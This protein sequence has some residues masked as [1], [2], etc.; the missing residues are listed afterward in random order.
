MFKAILSAIP[1]LGPLL[2]GGTAIVEA[3]AGNRAARDAAGHETDMATHAQFA[4][5]FRQIKGRTWW[6]SL[7]DGLNRLPR[8]VIVGM[9]I[10]Y[11]M[12]A[13]ADPIE[14]QIINTSLGAVPENMWLI[15]GV[16]IAFYFTVREIQKGRETKRM[17]LTAEAFDE[18]QRRISEL[19][20]Q[21]HVESGAYD[22]DMAD[23]DT[24]LSNASIEEWNRRRGNG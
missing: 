4:A 20:A 23:D 9:V 19:R 11:F 24:P 3:I 1:G 2:A 6:D 14:F 22:A 16:I 13:W 17:A 18:Q 8:P 10:A 21:Q 15:A 5:E 12:T 7:I